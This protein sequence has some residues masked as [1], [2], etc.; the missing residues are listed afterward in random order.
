MLPCPHSLAYTLT[1]NL[2]VCW[3]RTVQATQPGRQSSAAGTKRWESGGRPPEPS[4]ACESLLS[5][6]PR[7][8]VVVRGRTSWYEWHRFRPGL[9]RHGDYSR[10]LSASNPSTQTSSKQLP[11]GY[12]ELKLLC[13]KI[14]SQR[15]IRLVSFGRLRSSALVVLQVHLRVCLKASIVSA[16]LPS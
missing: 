11:E 12:R 5:W 14:K 15:P 9:V 7:A 16:P 4:Q 3:S 2:A 1:H 10:A 13:K 6:S 8:C